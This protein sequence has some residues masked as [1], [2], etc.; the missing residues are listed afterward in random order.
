M[1]PAYGGPKEIPHCKVNCQADAFENHIRDIG[2]VWACAWFGHDPDSEFTAETIKTLLD[3][4][5]QKLNDKG[6][7]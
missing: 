5:N 3:R 4:S 6:P 1:R 7:T 2:V